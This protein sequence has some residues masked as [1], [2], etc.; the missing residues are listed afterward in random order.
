MK[1]QLE[2]AWEGGGLDNPPMSM[3]FEQ[4][5]FIQECVLTNVLGA[6]VSFTARHVR[7]VYTNMQ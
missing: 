2:G 7:T 5:W 3:V 4:T 6:G 1:S